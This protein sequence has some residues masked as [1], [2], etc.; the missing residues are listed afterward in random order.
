MKKLLVFVTV[1]FI[2]FSAVQAQVIVDFEV[3]ASGTQGFANPSWGA[4]TT[5][6]ER[7]ADP[8]GRSTGVLAVS[9]DGSL[10]DRGNVEK[11]DFSPKNAHVLS[12]MAYS[13]KHLSGQR[14]HL[15]MRSRQCTLVRFTPATLYRCHSTQGKMD[16]FEFLHQGQ[17]PC[18]SY[19]FQSL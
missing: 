17:F 9:Y 18:E 4:A 8:T 12:I 16:T 10:G 6:V 14:S 13:T 1:S 5:G 7:I 19:G 2:A 15:H 3:A 11:P